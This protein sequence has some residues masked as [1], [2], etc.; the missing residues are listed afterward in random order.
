MPQRKS[1]S[2]W[3]LLAATLLLGS[4]CG[5]PFV[6]GDEGPTAAQ[7]RAECDGLAAQAIDAQDLAEATRLA[8]RASDCYAQEARRR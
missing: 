6:G 5:V 7:R 3:T 2:S 4:G 1:L 8:A